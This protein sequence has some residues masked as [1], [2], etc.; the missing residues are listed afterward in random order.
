[1]KGLS[2]IVFSLLCTFSLAQWPN[3]IDK[4][5]PINI[6]KDYN[7]I[8]G[9]QY[10][11]QGNTY[12]A[13][14][15]GVF[16]SKSY[17]YENSYLPIRFQKMD[18][19][20]VA[21]WNIDSTKIICNIYLTL[22]EKEGGL[23]VFYSKLDNIKSS[24]P[25]FNNML[26]CA[27]IDK[28]GLKKWDTELE[29]FNA[30]GGA[31]SPTSVK[32][33]TAGEI[34]LYFVTKQVV[35]FQKL[36]KL[37][38]KLLIENKKMSDVSIGFGDNLFVSTNAFVHTKS[39]I[40]TINENPAYLL[41]KRDKD[42]NDV[43]KKEVS[44]ETRDIVNVFFDANDN[45]FLLGYGIGVTLDLSKI[46]KNGNTL[47]ASKKVIDREF[48]SI[49]NHY[50][51]FDADSNLHLYLLISTSS[52]AKMYYIKMNEQ[53]EI[54]INKELENI[55]SRIVESNNTVPFGLYKEKLYDF[56]LNNKGNILLSWLKKAVNSTELYLSK[57]DAA[58]NSLWNEDKLID[59]DSTIISVTNIP[60]TDSTNAVFY[61]TGKF[62]YVNRY[63]SFHSSNF[64]LKQLTKNGNF[65]EL[66][67]NMPDKICRNSNLDL[68][69]HTEGTYEENNQFRVLLSDAKGDFSHA[70]EIA[71]SKQTAFTINN[72]TET[73]GDYKVKV[74]STYPV[75]EV[76]QP[77]SLKIL[78]IPQFTYEFK[79]EIMKFDS[80]LVKLRFLTGVPP[81]K[82]KLWDDKVV[83]T[84]SNTYETYIKPTVTSE[85]T[86]KL[87]AD[88][89]CANGPVSFKITV[90]EPLSTEWQ[91]RDNI[92]IY[93][94]P[95]TSNLT[96]EVN[97]EVMK[98]GSIL[99]YD[100]VGKP[101][102]QNHTSG[103]TVDLKGLIQGT[104][105]LKGY[106]N[107]RM[108]SRKILVER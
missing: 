57:F 45:T 46:D 79:T 87:V 48:S 44:I 94:I 78:E 93:P 73:E 40:N 33:N 28:S 15:S 30:F 106:I 104:Y 36:D 92:N 10:D 26:R 53:G 9:T 72:L 105:V 17:P 14:K 81:Y 83:Q 101:V 99:I 16:V 77:W 88:A 39:K 51:Y 50:Y 31:V 23:Y 32:V 2:T 21:L 69:L 95:A 25:I 4:R 65:N 52:G 19:K 47:V 91:A 66:S 54:L 62:Q 24:E 97:N 37:G 13:I 3:A 42:W 6:S 76:M 12:V 86:I 63:P 27:Y 74:V 98:N 8:S 59:R 18:K 108:F 64:Y 41:S 100:I 22:P 90:L 58:G 35:Y 43:W 34:E 84:S 68:K 85:Y 82:L 75:V 71:T 11:G 89:N 67:A 60:P 107:G 96:I 56:S 80:T 7:Q 102:Y 70:K 61:L 20:G 1:M 29:K 49:L 103:G 38:N 55:N 5:L